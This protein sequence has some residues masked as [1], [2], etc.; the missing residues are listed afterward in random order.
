[1]LDK[2][3]IRNAKNGSKAYNKGNRVASIIQN[4]S[5]VLS[6]FK[7]YKDIISDYIKNKENSLNRNDFIKYVYKL[8][9]KNYLFE[10]E[11]EDTCKKQPYKKLWEITRGVSEYGDSSIYNGAIYGSI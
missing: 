7:P 2:D 11:V 10:N 5:K 3:T 6:L 4:D 8:C 9:N 1:M